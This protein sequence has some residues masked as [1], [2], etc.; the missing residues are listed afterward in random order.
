MTDADPAAS[1]HLTAEIRAAYD[2]NGAAW[3]GGPRRIY[4]Q[5]ASS[6]LD[7]AAIEFAGPLR[8]M[9]APAPARLPPSCCAEEPAFSP[10]TFRRPC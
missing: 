4:D 3:D 7:A 10:L 2:E 6:L 1:A 5:L 8:L 9:P